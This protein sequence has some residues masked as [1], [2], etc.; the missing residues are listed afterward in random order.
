[1]PTEKRFTYHSKTWHNE[2]V[3]RITSGLY[4]G[5]LIESLPGTNTRPTSERLRQSWLNSIQMGLHDARILDLFSGSGA[6][7]LEALSRGAS[8]VI[9]V[10]ENPKAAQIIQQNIKSLGLV[11]Q[12]QV[13]VKK[14]E[15][16]LKYIEGEPSFDF[17]FMDPPYH[18]GFEEKILSEWPWD[19]VLADGGK[20]CIESA[21][22]KETG[23]EGVGYAPP[24]TLQIIRDEKY[25]DTQLTFYSKREES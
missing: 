23:K 5:R 18:Q 12:A 6:L 11:E 1:M 21:Y 14:A 15:S 9:F 24:A 13:L 8:F 4:R 25:S 22:R 3:L 10:E 16:C 7:G 17:V 2:N 20:L 19:T